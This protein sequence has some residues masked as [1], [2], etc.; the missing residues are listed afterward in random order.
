VLPTVAAQPSWE[1][2]P[3]QLIAP[4]RGTEGTHWGMGGVSTVGL[5]A[6]TGPALFYSAG[7]APP[8]HSFT[9][10]SQDALASLSPSA[11]SERPRTPPV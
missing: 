5:F 10:R 4:P 2:L 1:G 3:C 9:V 11:E 7:S 8:S 6:A